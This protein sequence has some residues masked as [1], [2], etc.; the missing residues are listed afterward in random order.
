MFQ[1]Y[2]A[3]AFSIIIGIL[4]AIAIAVADLDDESLGSSS[5]VDPHLPELVVAATSQ[6]GPAS[7]KYCDADWE[8]VGG[9]ATVTRKEARRSGRILVA[10]KPIKCM[11]DKDLTGLLSETDDDVGKWFKDGNEEKKQR[12]IDGTLAYCEY[13]HKVLRDTHEA[14]FQK[15]GIFNMKESGDYALTW[16]TKPRWKDGKMIKALRTFAIPQQLTPCIGAA[17]KRL[18]RELQHQGLESYLATAM[19][20]TDKNHPEYIPAKEEDLEQCVATTTTPVRN[21]CELYRGSVMY[22]HVRTQPRGTEVVD[23]R[24]G[25]RAIVPEGSDPL[26]RR[27]SKTNCLQGK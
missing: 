19:N 7:R 22:L 20:F 27:R 24:L 9:V 10:G 17:S 25:A 12:Y 1:T 6:E 21:S 4:L 11:C 8:K 2:S 5:K 13:Q 18:V 3:H 16:V 23:P 14:D 26:Y 15:F